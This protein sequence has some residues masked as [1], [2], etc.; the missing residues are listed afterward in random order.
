MTV[1]LDEEKIRG[2][3]LFFLNGQFEGAAAD[4][5][6]SAAGKTD[7]LIRGPRPQRLHRRV[8]DPERP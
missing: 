8:Q 6:L 3:L 7:I 2:L 1:Q 5:V 4:E